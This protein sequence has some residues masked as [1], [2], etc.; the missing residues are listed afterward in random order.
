[1]STAPVGIVEVG[2]VIWPTRRLRGCR[3]GRPHP[4]TSANGSPRL[5]TI[6]TQPSGAIGSE[7]ANSAWVPRAN[8]IAFTA[9]ASLQGYRKVSGVHVAFLQDGLGARSILY[10]A[11]VFDTWHC[12]LGASLTAV[13]RASRPRAVQCSHRQSR[14]LRG[15]RGHGWAT[16]TASRWKNTGPPAK[17]G[18]AHRA[19]TGISRAEVPASFESPAH[20]RAE[21]RRRLHQQS[22]GA[23][24][25]AFRL[26]ESG[27]TRAVFANPSARFSAAHHRSDLWRRLAGAHRGPAA[28]Q[29]GGRRMAMASG[30]AEVAR[31][32]T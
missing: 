3:L 26:V 10:G 4:C 5:K 23:P 14:R 17:G 8:H 2:R 15:W 22:E 27:P 19:S 11:W 16:L 25:T 21:R 30:W 18:D 29:D 6:S 7:C 28:G 12:F 13:W 24:P 1:M 31:G 9:W 32:L 20:R